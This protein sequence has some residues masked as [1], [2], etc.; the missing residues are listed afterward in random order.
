MS[1][2]AII[3]EPA[4]FQEGIIRILQEKLSEYEI[5]SY[6]P[7]QQKQ[8]HTCNHLMDLLII[9]INAS[10]NYLDLI[11]SFLRENVKIAVWWTSDVEMEKLVTLFQ[12]DLYG[13]LY[14]G[15]DISELIFAIKSILNGMKYTYPHFI[16]ILVNDYLRLSSEKARRPV[17]LL[18]QREWDILEL[19]V[20]GKKNRGIANYLYV[21][22]DT[23]KNHVSS[24]L[25]KLDVPDRNNAALLAVK[26]RWFVL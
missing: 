26:E 14:N 22:T 4:L 19:I 6:N 7:N 12:L 16:N 15:M 8:F 17:G 25:K 5:V 9:E 18:T 21:S 24:I 1:K 20:K 2:I 11:E 3:T 23:V 13:Y 10:T